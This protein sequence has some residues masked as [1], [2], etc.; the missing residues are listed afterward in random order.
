MMQRQQARCLTAWAAACFLCASCSSGPHESNATESAR[1]AGTGD[2]AEVAQ[3]QVNAPSKACSAISGSF[4][5]TIIV[6]NQWTIDKCR[7][8]AAGIGAS[9][10]QLG[11]LR[12]TTFE[13]AACND[14]CLP[15]KNFLA[16]NW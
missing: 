6:A 12:G 13:W 7:Q 16:C 9:H 3:A 4:R 5:D 14:G 8:Y 2:I 15:P 11:C 10:Y 1:P